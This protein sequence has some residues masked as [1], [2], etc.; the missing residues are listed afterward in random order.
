VSL[1]EATRLPLAAELHRT[2]GGRSDFAIT[3]TR[4]HLGAPS[5]TA[6]RFAPPAGTTVH[7][8]SS[9][10]GSELV[11]DAARLLAAATGR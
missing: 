11:A 5:P 1:D 9:T 7:T 6:L 4:L 2:P 8:V 10:A 3:F